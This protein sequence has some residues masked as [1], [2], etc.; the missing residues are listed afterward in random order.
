MMAAQPNSRTRRPVAVILRIAP[1][2]AIV[3]NEKVF[4]MEVGLEKLSQDED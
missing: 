2:M 3:R 4:G 1:P